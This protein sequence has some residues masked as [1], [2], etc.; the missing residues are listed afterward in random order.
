MI[1][2]LK[3][4]EGL[5]FI[6]KVISIY[7]IWT[8]I[9]TSFNNIAILEP[10][11]ISLND[12]FAARY[13]AVSSWI[14]EN[15]FNYDLMYNK[16]NI[17]PKGNAGIYVGNHC[18]GISAKFIF[19]AVILSLKGRWFDKLWFISLGILTILSINTIRIVLLTMQHA[20]GKFMLFDLNH[21]YTFVLIVY[22]IIFGLIMIWEKY[23]AHKKS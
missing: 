7:L 21:R 3:K 22:A 15:W 19:I 8:I 4:N 12:F 9:R 5:F 20:E 1:E 6:I 10:F 14:L 17:L 23:F 13:V 18:I 11:W 16:R 2:N